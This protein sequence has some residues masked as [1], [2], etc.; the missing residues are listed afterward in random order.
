MLSHVFTSNIFALVWFAQLLEKKLLIIFRPV[1]CQR[2]SLIGLIRRKTMFWFLRFLRH[3][4]FC[5]L[6][7]RLGPRHWLQ[8]VLQYDFKV[9]LPCGIYRWQSATKTI[10]FSFVT[11]RYKNVPDRA[12]LKDSRPEFNLNTTLNTGLKSIFF[13][14]EWK[15]SKQ[16]YKE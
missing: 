9:V 13:H 14:C 2:S 16:F 4:S 3:C 12:V 7:V 8:V 11:I 15:S 10:S 6:S 1:K 5:R